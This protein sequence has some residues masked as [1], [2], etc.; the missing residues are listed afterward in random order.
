MKRLRLV[1]L[2]VV[3]IICFSS[4]VYAAVPQVIN[5]QGRFTDKDNN[6][7]SGNYLVTFRFYDVASGGAPLWEEGHILVMENGVFNA[8]LGSIKPLDI[9]FDKDL[10][11]GIEV[12][13][14]GEMTPRVKLTSS[15]YA[16]N[17]Q[18]IDM[19]SSTQLMRNDID[20]VMSG[21][22]TL[23]KDLILT[24]ARGNEYHMW[25]DDSGKVRVKQ[26]MPASDK[27]GAMLLTETAGKVSGGFMQSATFILLAVAVLVL[28]LVLYSL[29]KKK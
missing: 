9:D 23:K 7:L 15:A 24:D 2:V 12:A 29:K 17:A 13:S 28:A 27:D 5:Y 6:P 26:G 14:D 25:V 18:A 22:L 20:S 1:M 3:G 19:L 10:W 4:L 21:S 16:F 8:S 11:M